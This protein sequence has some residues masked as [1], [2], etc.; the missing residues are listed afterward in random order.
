M[1][2]RRSGDVGTENASILN[3]FPTVTFPNMM[4]AYTSSVFFPV[5]PL[6]AVLKKIHSLGGGD[7]RRLTT[8]DMMSQFFESRKSIVTFEA[9]RFSKLE[10]ATDVVP[11]TVDRPLE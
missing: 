4:T 5:E 7:G 6:R 2:H 11:G 9:R 10:F 3:R 1:S 8:D